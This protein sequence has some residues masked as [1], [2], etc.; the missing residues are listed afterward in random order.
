MGREG[1]GEKGRVGDPAPEVVANPSR[2]VAR[3][4]AIWRKGEENPT[5]GKP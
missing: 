2:G 4:S 5:C 1:E 3:E